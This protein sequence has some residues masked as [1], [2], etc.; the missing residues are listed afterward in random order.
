[1]LIAFTERRDDGYGPDAQL[2]EFFIFSLSDLSYWTNFALVGVL[3]CFL[4]Q[5]PYFVSCIHST[6]FSFSLLILSG[7]KVN[8]EAFE[9]SFIQKALLFSLR[10]SRLTWS[11]SIFLC[12]KPNNSFFTKQSRQRNAKLPPLLRALV[13]PVRSTVIGSSGVSIKKKKE[14]FRK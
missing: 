4:R 7:G 9:P 5:M 2:G 3:S 14:K 10:K 1:M 13:H 8:K 6:S 11:N 12:G